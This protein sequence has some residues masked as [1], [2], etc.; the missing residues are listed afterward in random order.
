M[1]A[2]G[3]DR[4]ET[5]SSDLVAINATSALHTAEFSRPDVR[6]VHAARLLPSECFGAG[7]DEP[8][9]YCP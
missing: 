8:L 2:A 4:S 1:R 6:Q 9:G 5:L 3:Y 7:L